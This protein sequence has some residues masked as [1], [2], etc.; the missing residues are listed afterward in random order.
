MSTVGAFFQPKT[1]C[2]SL[3]FAVEEVKKIIDWPKERS[4]ALIKQGRSLLIMCVFCK[5][6]VRD[7]FNASCQA[8]ISSRFSLKSSNNDLQ[9]LQNKLRKKFLV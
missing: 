1:M 6:G 3:L 5:V 9:V 7:G 8:N 2:L 4:L